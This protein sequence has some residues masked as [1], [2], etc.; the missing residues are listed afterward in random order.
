[1]PSG[2]FTPIMVRQPG[3]SP[4]LPDAACDLRTDIAPSRLACFEVRRWPA[5]HSGMTCKPCG[6]TLS[7]PIVGNDFLSP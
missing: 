4:K 6:T 5:L 3:S 1:M 2:I 7:T